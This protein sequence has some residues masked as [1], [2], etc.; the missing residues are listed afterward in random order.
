MSL[1]RARQIGTDL[2]EKSQEFQM[3]VPSITVGDGDT[4][5]DIHRRKQ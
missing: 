3:P 2:A 5:G 1:P 4:A